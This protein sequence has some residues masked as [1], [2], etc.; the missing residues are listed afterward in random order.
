MT[1]GER[2]PTVVR[3]RS[4]L[5]DIE[6][7]LRRF[8]VTAALVH[9]AGR[10]IVEVGDVSWPVHIHSMRKSIIS[11]LFGQACD[12]GEIDLKA[13]L[14]DLE[15]DDTPSLTDKEKSA[16]VT[17]LLAARSGVYLCAEDAGALG[18]PP[19]G[20]HPPGT[21]WC[22]N[23]W[24]FN[25]LGNIYERITGRSLFVA[26]EHDLARPLGMVDW[27]IYRHGSYQYR[28]DILG[29]TL[30]Y[31]NYTFH[32]SAR[33]IAKVGQ[34]YLN[35]G[36]WNGRRL[37]SPEWIARSTDQVSRTNHPAGLL[38]MYGYCWWVAGPSDELSDIGIA[39]T[40]Y[41]AIGFGGNFLTVLP[42]I[43]TLVTVVTDTA[44]ALAGSS[45][46]Q[47]EPMTND[48]YHELLVHLAA[49]LS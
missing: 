29:G 24:D 18:Q 2:P 46:P 45:T 38:G 5:A 15:I 48:D 9:R 39:H 44:T 41:S 42:E 33:D 14:G 19:R 6:Q 3:A 20:S 10:T 22:Y 28:T 37:L 17:D 32:L 7:R 34:L 25:V 30:R 12:R 36:L 21:F 40:L 1:C 47:P 27:D 26:F 23:N 49:A 16:T 35:N 4:D 8:D 31:P 13:T 43:G 11:A